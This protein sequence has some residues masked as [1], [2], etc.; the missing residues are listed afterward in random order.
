MLPAED[1]EM[2]LP[3]TSVMVI[4]VLLKVA[5]TCATPEVMFFFSRLRKRP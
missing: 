2:A 3:C 5:R 4:V 1:Q